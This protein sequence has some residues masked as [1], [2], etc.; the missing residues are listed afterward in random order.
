MAKARTKKEGYIDLEMVITKEGNQ[1]SSWCPAL[2]V[3]S[4]GDT[5]D[6][7]V[8]NLCDAIGCYLE[9]LKE[10]G[11]LGKVL[12]E[13]GIKVVRGDEPVI[14]NS[15]ITHCRQKVSVD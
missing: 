12:Q 4:C 15:F 8:K 14:P 3:A 1:Y 13:K 10:D 6:E 2:D 11:E 9:A 5:P 7:A